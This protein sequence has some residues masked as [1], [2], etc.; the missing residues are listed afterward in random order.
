M[1]FGIWGLHRSIVR[2]VIP[3]V[4]FRSCAATRAPSALS[5]GGILGGRSCMPSRLLSATG[6]WMALAVVLV[7]LMLSL[8]VC[9]HTAFFTRLTSVIVRSMT[10][11]FCSCLGV[12]P[13]VV[14]FTAP[15]C[16]TLTSILVSPYLPV[17]ADLRFW[18]SHCTFYCCI[19]HQLTCVLA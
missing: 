17:A 10:S 18:A 3:A 9:F 1:L 7:G 8:P 13:H 14:R 4:T 6:A 16:N 15:C 11:G 5:I 19:W 12:Q 2:R